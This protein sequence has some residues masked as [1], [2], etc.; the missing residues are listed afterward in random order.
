MATDNKKITIVGIYSG[1]NLLF[2]DAKI[3]KASIK[4]TATVMNHPVESGSVITDHVI[5]NPYEITFQL[6][7]S[8]TNN[9]STY[10]SIKKSFLESS[11]L[12]VHTKSG[13]YSN[14]IISMMPHE[15]SV[16]AF[17]SLAMTVTLKQV[18]LVKKTSIAAPKS[19]KNSNTISTGKQNPKNVDT[20]TPKESA[21]LRLI[22]SRS[23]KQGQK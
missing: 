22:A 16:E 3:M 2:K 20:P 17:N 14:M 21:L 7:I 11:S 15:E 6:M 9:Q 8:S 18:I 23:G 4:E 10:S 1:K 13:V 19:D 12:T 5:I